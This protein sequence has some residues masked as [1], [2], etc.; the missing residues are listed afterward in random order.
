MLAPYP[1]RREQ[2][3]HAL[4]QWLLRVFGAMRSGAWDRGRLRSTLD[5]IL[6]LERELTT[7][8]DEEMRARANL[9]RPELLRRG[10]APELVAQAFALAREATWRCLGLRHY[11][12]QLMGGLTLL[13]GALAEMQTGEGKTIV[14]ILPAITAALGG[15]SVHIVTVNDYLAKRDAEALAP[16]FNAL[17]LTVG[18]IQGGQDLESR[19]AAYGCDVTYCTNKELVFDYL[20]DRIASRETR[21]RL[22][23]GGAA[24]AAGGLAPPYLLRGLHFAIIDEADSVLID[25]ARTPLIISAEKDEDI[26]SQRYQAAL[27]IA[28]SLTAGE[29]Y[30]LYD[31]D[32]VVRLTASGADAVA[33]QS[34]RLDPVWRSRRARDELVVEGT[35]SARTLSPGQALH[36]CGRQGADRR[37]VYG[38]H[39]ARSY[40]GTRPSSAHRSQGRL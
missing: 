10:F 38:A 23:Q 4:D 2:R 37:R 8:S 11:H 30:E 35:D 1:E 29:H 39:D 19:R 27:E 13:D 3:A 26:N 6:S 33:A 5:L 34:H 40:V 18:L 16:V 9:L 36:H 22:A 15:A 21:K 25:E 31:R 14:A 7:L 20:K 28:R 17:G 32:R 12:V 24:H